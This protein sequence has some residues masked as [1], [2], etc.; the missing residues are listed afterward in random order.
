MHI[1]PPY[2]IVDNRY[3]PISWIMTPFK[4]GQHTVLELFYNCLS[5]SANVLLL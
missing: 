2:M 4:E 5:T 1:F 3:S